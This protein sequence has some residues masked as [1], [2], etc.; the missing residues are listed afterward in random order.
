MKWNSEGFYEPC[1][2]PV[3]TLFNMQRVCPFNLSRDTL[4][5]EDELA[6]EFF[7]GKGYLDSEVGFYKKYMWV[8][9]NILERLHPP[10]V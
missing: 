2:S 9:L 6:H 10:V 4:V 7:D 8:I 1:F 3:S 5:N